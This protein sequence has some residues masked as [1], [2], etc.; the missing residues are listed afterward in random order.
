MQVPVFILF[1]SI[2]KCSSTV[3][4]VYGRV[5]FVD[6]G[7]TFFTPQ[8]LMISGACPP[9]APSL[10]NKIT[11]FEFVIQ[12]SKKNRTHNHARDVFDKSMLLISENP[13]NI[14]TNFFPF[15]HFV[16]F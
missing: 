14:S 6:E 1:T 13:C 16:L 8:T 3:L 10:I 9:P 4:V 11:I 15:M 2:S 5:G 12:E 7:K